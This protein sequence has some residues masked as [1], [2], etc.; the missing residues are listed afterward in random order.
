M[1][2]HPLDFKLYLQLFAIPTRYLYIC[3]ALSKKQHGSVY[4]D[5]AKR[6]NDIILLL[7]LRHFHRRWII[8]NKTLTRFY[9]LYISLYT[10]Q[11]KRGVG[12]LFISSSRAVEGL[13]KGYICSS[14]AFS[15]IYPFGNW[16]IQL[17]GIRN[18]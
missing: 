5:Y 18:V 3:S 10:Y 7:K 6:F 13:N 4:F 16:W 9:L 17:I 1:A 8:G 12:L 11:D 2:R 15:F 14:Y